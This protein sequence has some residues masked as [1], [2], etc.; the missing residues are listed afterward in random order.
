MENKKYRTSR[1]S[2]NRIIRSLF[3]LILLLC[4]INHPY[5]V[6]ADTKG[7]FVVNSMTDLAGSNDAA[8]GNGICAS[9]AGDCT[10]RA[11]IQETNAL[12]GADTIQFDASVTMVIVQTALPALTDTTGGTTIS[13]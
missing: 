9:S 11:A 13:G 4:L 6:L 1:R 5:P 12:Q 2:A 3:I 7:A 8:P 10:L